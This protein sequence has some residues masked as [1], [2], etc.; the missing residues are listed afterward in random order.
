MLCEFLEDAFPSY[1]P[2]ILPADPYARAIV[3]IWID[4]ITKQVV[5]GYMRTMQAQ[6]PAKQ[7]EHLEEYYGALRTLSKQVKGPYFLGD[8][9]SLVDVAIAPWVV[10]DYVLKENRGYDRAAVGEGWQAYAEALENRESV[11]K[12]MSVSRV[13]CVRVTP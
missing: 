3:R 1:T 8:E 9:F 13:R 4:H 12:T 7:R 10:R 6:D 5:P 2:H 11:K